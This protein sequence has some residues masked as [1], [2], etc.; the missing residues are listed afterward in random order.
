[1]LFIS[2]RLAPFRYFRWLSLSRYF[3]HFLSAFTIH[4]F[5]ELL[6]YATRHAAAASASRCLSD[7]SAPRQPRFSS[8][9]FSLPRH[10]RR[11]FAITSRYHFHAMPAASAIFFAAIH[12][13]RQRLRLLAAILRWR[14]YFLDVSCFHFPHISLPLFSSIFT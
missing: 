4:Y 10:C 9:L 14:C 8:P 12:A 2:F 5:I 6:P 3:S 13:A 7:Y 11:A 1:L